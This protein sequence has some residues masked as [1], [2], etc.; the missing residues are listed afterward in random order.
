MQGAWQAV[1]LTALAGA[2]CVVARREQAFQVHRRQL[3]ATILHP[4][5]IT[6]LAPL[7]VALGIWLL[8]LSE[9]QLV[10]LMVMMVS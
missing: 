1:V 8:Y 2:A 10:E 3:R 6:F 9:K 5:T 4:G 7:I